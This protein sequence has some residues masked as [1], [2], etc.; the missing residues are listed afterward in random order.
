MRSLRN[1]QSFD[2][3]APHGLL[4]LA[5]VANQEIARLLSERLVLFA[6]LE[7]VLRSPTVLLRE[8]SGNLMAMHLKTVRNCGS[9]T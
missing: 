2:A 7:E 1:I 3:R 9:H 6:R 8:S 4:F 5:S